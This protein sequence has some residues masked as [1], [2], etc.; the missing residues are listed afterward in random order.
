MIDGPAVRIG[1]PERENGCKN[2]RLNVDFSTEDSSVFSLFLILS[3]AR[4][5]YVSAAPASI[6]RI[7]SPMEM[8]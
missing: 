4:S 5:V 3:L 2:L 1:A 6:H 8:R 7:S